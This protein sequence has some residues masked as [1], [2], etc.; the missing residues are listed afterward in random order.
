MLESDY[1]ASVALL[2]QPLIQTHHYAVILRKIH[3]FLQFEWE[4]SISHTY[5]EAN[6]VADGLA[7]LSHSFNPD[8]YLFH[9][10]PPNLVY[11]SSLNLLLIR[12]KKKK[13]VI[14]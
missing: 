5:T 11:V 14:N 2:N 10:P 1:E 12:K 13:K 7:N 4:V 9:D 8:T 3:Q 6:R